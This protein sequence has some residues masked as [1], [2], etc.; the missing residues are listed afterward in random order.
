MP[1]HTTSKR[2]ADTLYREWIRYEG[3]YLSVVKAYSEPPSSIA[4]RFLNINMYHS[5]KVVSILGFI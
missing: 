5:T 1:S 4:K 2:E 3:I